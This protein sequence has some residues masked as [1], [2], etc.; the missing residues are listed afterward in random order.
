[1]KKMQLIENTIFLRKDPQLSR[2]AAVGVQLRASSPTG[3]ENK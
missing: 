3:A 1:M 2:V